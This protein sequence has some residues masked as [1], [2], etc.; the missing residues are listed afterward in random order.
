MAATRP[1]TGVEAAPVSANQVPAPFEGRVLKWFPK[2][3]GPG[4]IDGVGAKRLLGTPRLDPA[5]VLVREAGSE[6]LGRS[7][8][9]AEHRLH[10][11][12]SASQWDGGGDSSQRVFTEDPPKTGL[13]ELLRRDEIWALE[14]SDRGR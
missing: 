8:H 14:V 6:Q 9:C 4:D 2:Q 1:T 11:E 10:P 3:F 12:S 7:R 5:W 13:A